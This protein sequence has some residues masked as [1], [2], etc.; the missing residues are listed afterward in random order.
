MAICTNPKVFSDL[1]EDFIAQYENAAK[2]DTLEDVD[3]T[4]I[5]ETLERLYAYRKA[6]KAGDTEYIKAQG[7][8]INNLE[9]RS[10]LA[11]NTFRQIFG[12]TFSFTEG[13]SSF[14]KNG[15]FEKVSFVDGGVKIHYF[16]R[17]ASKDF[18]FAL[19]SD[20]RS[21]NK[22]KSFI[23]VPGFRKF[24]DAYNFAEE[25]KLRAQIIL[26]SEEG[27]K[28]TLNEKY[29]EVDYIHGNIDSMKAMLKKLHALGG[30]KA[31]D[32]EMERYMGL[33]EKMDP[34]FFD[35]LKL[36]VQEQA[37]R[38]G[39]V[40]R[41][42]RIDIK[43]KGTPRS[44]G[45]QQSEASIYM[46]EVFHSMTKTAIAAK[47]A[48]SEK[49]KRQLDHL[50]ELARA[51]LKPEDFL[52]D[53]KDSIDPEKE[54]ALAEKLYDYILNGETYRYEFLAKGIVQPEIA[55][56][57][58]K[59]QVRD[60][61]G[62]KS[63]LDRLMDLFELVGQVLTGTVN[64]KN[65]NS[66]VHD[67]LVN[68][69]Y[70]FAEINT[71]KNQSMLER[72]GLFARVWDIVL[73]DPD[74]YLSNK[75]N[76][77]TEGTIEKLAT[78]E[79]K[80]VPKDLY[81]RTKATAEH[82][83]LSL[84]NPTYTKVMGAV[85]SA[86]GLRPDGTIREIVSGLFATEPVQKVGEFLV[87]QA[88]YVDKLR[89]E[90]IGLTVD[91]VLMKFKERPSKEMEEFL[92]TVLADTDLASLFGKTSAAYDV[93]LVKSRVFNNETLRKLLT[94]D[95]VLDNF[96]KEAKRAL[97]DLDATHY[98]WHS[99]QAVGLGIYMA[100][101]QGSLSQN[102]NATNIAEGIHST[103]SKQA[104]AKV[105]KAIDELATLVAIKN[106][107]RVA[108]T[109]VAE[110]MKTEWEGVQHV[111]DV[112]EGFKKN[113]KV[114]VFKNNSR[115]Q[116]KGY[117][118]EV[119]DDT[120]V[121]EVALLEDRASMEAQGFTYRATLAPKVGD[122]NKKPMAL[123]ITDVASRPERLRGGVRMGQIR[124][125][126]FTIT[127][128][129]YKD[130]EG[131]SNG[132]IRERAQREIND[133][134]RLAIEEAKKMEKGEF[135]FKE[136]VF[137]VVPL[138]NNDGKVIDYRYM[139]NKETKLNNL[140]PERRIS[141]VMGRSFGTL[142]DKEMSAAHNKKVLSVLKEDM[143]ENWK[144]GTKG[145]DGLTDFTLIGPNVK[146]PEMRKLYYMLPREFQEFINS[147]EDKTL[148]VRTSFKNMY[149]GYS[150]LSIMDFPGLAK[151][152]P[153]VLAKWIR[154]AE[155]IWMEIVQ[156][157]KTNILMKMP[158]VTLSNFVSNCFYLAMRGY[159]PVSILTMQLDSYREI[160]RY[161]GNVRKR[162]ELLNT[163]RDLTVAKGRSNL[164]EKRTKEINLELKRVNG[165]L[166][167]VES[168]IKDSRIHELV[169]MG[170]DQTVEDIASNVTR[171]TNRVS[172]YFNE[173]MEN[174]P[175]I[176]RTGVDYLFLTKRTAP[177]KIVNEFLE[178]TDLMARDIQNTM[179]KR[180]EVRQANGE[181]P[182]PQWWL[183]KQ[184]KGYKAKARLTGEERAK[185][186]QEAEVFRKYE[187]VE[188]YINYALPSGQMEEYLN[189]VGILMFTKYVKRIQRII[190]KTGGRGPLKAM[191]GLFGV[192]YLGGLPSIHEQS[193]LAKDWY[194]D[195][196]GPG[197]V[198]PIYG[199]TDILMNIL[200][201][202]L[203]KASTFDFSIH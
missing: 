10:Q 142:L 53:P 118:K 73:N 39:G 64:I 194:T 94:D 125:K 1:V 203:L 36:Y 192:S 143:E 196:L 104:K 160:K 61:Q 9:E 42:N 153:K 157:A 154:V 59:V 105:V 70:D 178:I 58:A 62:K 99:N 119:F 30:D 107:D 181:E 60:T 8:L 108:R 46:E 167:A 135:D 183:K 15:V 72:R 84:V 130:G 69:A 165:E 120:I 124:S 133:I 91:S 12:S 80:E 29:E 127:E 28:F 116:I 147:R 14:I 21:T 85:A 186:L 151:I 57:L 164:S 67:A 20:G 185:F 5:N 68:L 146:D 47:T 111:A 95:T 182:L 48:A 123:Y 97:K 7:F 199:P 96:I 32:A 202:S 87:L 71:R 101:H 102:L 76:D 191:L 188:D 79:Y 65:K 6:I 83:A 77:L 115:N 37:E 106:T 27:A 43:V 33:L 45:N 126:G 93:G 174:L 16:H 41:A 81:G 128:A 171:D 195:S 2:D 117:T 197:N 31:S 200:T 173:K 63:I 134:Q 13:N 24:V 51:Q 11:T 22:G 113:S 169:E 55:K 150:Q 201:P 121:M 145:V 50:I 131:F 180:A 190:T 34:K 198:F 140:N 122:K 161:N 168:N 82:I 26:G 137:G 89:N 148:A 110:L 193:F 152:T 159:D 112:I 184:P 144:Q 172:K 149:F 98:D 54:Q 177:Y 114:T 139:M 75:I 166:K 17:G 162:Q 35:S 52:P 170:L 56:A 3:S 86:Y 66:N 187:L 141:E 4:P 176:A 100:T 175:S 88:G 25:N 136:A 44:L 109:Q 90:Q 74:R 40:A 38:S 18:T 132:V 23:T 78:K 155:T 19:S 103:H 189:K 156:V 179:E 163:Q 129:A 138:I 92:T 158:T 49:L